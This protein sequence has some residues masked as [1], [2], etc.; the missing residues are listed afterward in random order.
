MSD[1]LAR[2]S[3]GTHGFAAPAP[4]PWLTA[5]REAAVRKSLQGTTRGCGVAGAAGLVAKPAPPR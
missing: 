2:R 4:P 1:P 3:F 5:A